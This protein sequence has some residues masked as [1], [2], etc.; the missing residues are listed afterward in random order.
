MAKKRRPKYEDDDEVE[1]SAGNVGG[2]LGGLVQIG[3]TQ[4]AASEKAQAATADQAEEEAG[5]NF[6]AAQAQRQ[7][8]LEAARMRALG[9]QMIA[10]QKTAYAA[11]GVDT[12]SG[13]PL[14]VMADTRL[15]SDLDAARAENDAAVEAWGYRLQKEKSRRNLQRTYDSLNREVIGG[16]LSGTASLI[17]SG[18]GK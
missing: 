18:A 10:R 3:M 2:A 8:S 7:G 9:T 14:A 6:D 13:T 5:L 11:S 12:T 16:I 17:S 4:W 15:M 1:G